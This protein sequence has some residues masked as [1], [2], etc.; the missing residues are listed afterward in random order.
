MIA[1]L[2]AA[3]VS[4]LSSVFNASS[5]LITMDI[6]KKIRPG[7]SEKQLVFAGRTIYHADSNHRSPVD[8]DDPS[9]ERSDLSVSSSRTG[10][11]QSP[12]RC[13]VHYGDCM[14]KSFSQSCNL[15]SCF[16]G[17]IGRTPFYPRRFVQ[18]R[19]IQV[20]LFK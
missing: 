19:R 7:S 1:A 6:Y 13:C 14:E 9:H 4:S 20:R 8:P 18:I 3:L 2:L 15:H 16:R 12:D 11:Y 5:T 10:I 17:Y